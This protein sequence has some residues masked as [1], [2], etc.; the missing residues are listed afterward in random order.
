M[1]KYSIQSVTG[2]VKKTSSAL[3]SRTPNAF[4]NDLGALQ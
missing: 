4:G 2:V 3:I 1:N